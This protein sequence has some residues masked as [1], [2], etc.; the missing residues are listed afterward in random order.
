[1][2]M[3]NERSDLNI[4]YSLHEEFVIRWKTNTS[5][6]NMTNKYFLKVSGKRYFISDATDVILMNWK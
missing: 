5:C 3:V 4:V 1:M 6:K 2:R